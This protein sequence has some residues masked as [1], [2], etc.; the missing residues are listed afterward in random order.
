MRPASTFTSNPL[1]VEAMR[2]V[3]RRLDAVN[4]QYIR[5]KLSSIGPFP[6]GIAP[7]A[8]KPLADTGESSVSFAMLLPLI[9]IL[10]TITG[11]VYPA[12]DLTAGERERGTMEALIAAPVPRQHL[13]F[14]KY[15]AVLTVAL[16]TA[17]VNLTAM[18]V[19]LYATGIGPV[20]F[21]EGGVTPQTVSFVFGLTILFAAFF[22]AVLLAVTSFARSF[23]EAQAY[24]IPL[25]LLSISPGVMS[26]MPG[27]ELNRLLA[28][29][30]LINIVLL[31]QYCDVLGK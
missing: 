29:T 19:T 24:L 30:P 10:M 20:L 9:L 23:K 7:S 28:V 1:S 27:L 17:V 31:G 2:A 25:M 22:S 11:A 14:A 18:T 13:L 8:R 26:L 12:I 4:Q 21:G 15:I 16:L 5:E 6:K 3:E